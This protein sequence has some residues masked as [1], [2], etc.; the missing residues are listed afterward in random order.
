MRWVT[1]S[2]TNR[3]ISRPGVR[4]ALAV[5]PALVPGVCLLLQLIPGTSSPL[6]NVWLGFGLMMAPV[7][8]WCGLLTK[9]QNHGPFLAALGLV[10]ALVAVVSVWQGIPCLA[11]LGQV[12]V[13]SVLGLALARQFKRPWWL[14]L[15]AVGALVADLWSVFAGPTRLALEKAPAALSY[16]LMQAPALGG[17]EGMALGISDILFLCL[18]L[19]GARVCRLRVGWSMGAMLAGLMVTTGLAVAAGVALPA[20]PLLATGF[21]SANADLIVRDV[22]SGLRSPE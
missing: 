22:R 7:A 3:R 14:G 4:C 2:T 12:V 10:G 9:A 13:A 17:G 18:F 21:L 19:E 1:G 6:I 15:A 16:L 11:A 5:S 20:L 8:T